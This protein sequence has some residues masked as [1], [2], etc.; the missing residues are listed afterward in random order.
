MMRV[1][2]ARDSEAQPT[3]IVLKSKAS[4]KESKAE[5]K[6]S[7]T[8]KRQQMLS[9]CRIMEYDLIE[10]QGLSDLLDS[11]SLAVLR[12]PYAGK[13]AAWRFVS[14]HGRCI[15]G[16]NGLSTH[17]GTLAYSFDFKLAVGTPVRAVRAGWAVAAVS[18]FTAGGARAHLAPRA[19]FVAIKHV[20]GSYARSH[21]SVQVDFRV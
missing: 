16:V 14:G 19:N 1:E 15:Q 10:T 12:L 11:S 3:A 5:A 7:I 21:A 9:E 20:D 13:S 17:R 4:K 8:D 18:H 6:S 2:D